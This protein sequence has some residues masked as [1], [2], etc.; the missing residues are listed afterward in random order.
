M[1]RDS[2]VA[3]LYLRS[4]PP[5]PGGAADCAGVDDVGVV[6]AHGYVPALGGAHGIAVG[7]WD[8]ALWRAARR[9]DR[10]VVLL[11]GVDAVGMPGVDGGVVELG[12]RLVVYGRPRL[13]AVEGD[14][15][16]AVVPLDHALG[17]ARVDPQVVVV[18]VW[19]RH[20][21]K[22]ATCVVRPEGL[23][24]E[25]PH[26]VGPRG[27][28]EDVV[29][30]EGALPDG[31]A[32]VD[33]LPGVAAVV[34]EQEHAVLC[35]DDGP[36]PPGPGG[37]RGDAYAA[38]YPVGHAGAVGQ[39][40]PCVAAVRRPP[41]AALR[42]CADEAPGS[43]EHLPHRGVEDSG[44]VG[45]HRQVDRAGPV[46]LEQD[47]LPRAAA[48]GGAEDA[49]LLVGA[50]GVSERR[51]VEPVGVA[52]VDPYAGDVPRVVE[53][54][55]LPGGAGVGGAVY[56][57]AVGD[58]AADARLARAGVYDRRVCV[59]YGEGADGGG[60]EESV[61]HVAPVCPAVGG[62]PDSARACAE[63]EGLP[64]LGV[65]G[66]GHDAPPPVRADRPPLHGAKVLRTQF[67]AQR[68]LRSRRDIWLASLS[69]GRGRSARL[70]PESDRRVDVALHQCA[71]SAA[72]SPSSQPSPAR[73]EGGRA[74]RSPCS[75]LGR[76]QASAVCQGPGVELE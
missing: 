15:R 25:G 32:V 56:A 75:A 47:A 40:G 7:E 3:W 29:V 31:G 53:A 12:G 17:V 61:G 44:V 41:Q 23:D 26:G 62:L 48:V 57:V 6:G 58:V 63:V 68:G 13:A 4:A 60:A 8:C 27:V 10:A 5:P 11:G 1:M 30:V 67:E 74:R 59:G 73:G 76:C 55:V 65:A 36:D 19:G 69:S 64:L 38:L 45:V 49:A 50:E 33:A 72:A 2:P 43:S 24:R 52:R 18:A 37:G 71:L 70:Q 54:D 22:R 42:P 28:G 35:L 46:A 21:G 34:R 51:D 16:A 66:H 39:V 9:A 14:A 20:H